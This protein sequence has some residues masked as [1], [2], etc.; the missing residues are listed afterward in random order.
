ML[1]SDSRPDILIGSGDAKM[2]KTSLHP[3]GRHRHMEGSEECR[4]E[5][6]AGVLGGLR[7]DL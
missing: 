3:Q 5:E 4:R 6:R 2:N 1:S 7:D